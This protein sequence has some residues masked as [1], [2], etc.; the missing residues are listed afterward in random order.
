MDSML[1][2]GD[3]EL[4][5]NPL[6]LRKNNNNDYYESNLSITN[7]SNH[8][9]IFKIYVNQKQSNYNVNPSTSFLK[10][11]SQLNVQV[12][13]N[14]TENIEENTKDKFLIRFFAIN[15]TIESI[16]EAKLMIKNKNYNEED[17]YEEVV[18]IIIN[19][20]DYQ[21]NNLNIDILDENKL[22][23]IEFNVDEAIPAYQ[24]MNN[25]MK[26]Q[27]SN[28]ERAIENYENQLQNIRVNKE[29]KNKKDNSL[30]KNSNKKENPGLNKNFMILFLLIS[31]VFGGYF[32]KI[33]NNFF[34][35]KK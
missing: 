32:A 34:P 12:R 10:P 26:N 11:N 21:F 16:E 23:E 33:K 22:K 15:T 6:E 14:I 13:K 25:N 19:K 29:S 3:I 35:N 5:S 4:F 28:F 31:F 1:K 30:N 7:K 27:I 20:D 9:I 8:Y 2:E 24:N 17:K 18:N